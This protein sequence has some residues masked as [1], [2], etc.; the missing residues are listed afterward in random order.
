MLSCCACGRR[1]GALVYIGATYDTL[2]SQSHLT[3][4]FKEDCQH[5]LTALGQRR[6]LP[7]AIALGAA[8]QA[9]HPDGARVRDSMQLI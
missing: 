8:F 7:H 4:E 2:E 9:S 5:N 3:F 1:C 6:L